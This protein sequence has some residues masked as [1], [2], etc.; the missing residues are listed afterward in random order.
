LK[1]EAKRF[2][3]EKHP[4]RLARRHAAVDNVFGDGFGFRLKAGRSFLV[5]FFKKEPLAYFCNL[6][7]VRLKS[8]RIRHG[9]DNLSTRRN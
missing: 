4:R 3:F 8:V 9:A 5:L 6:E 2:F 1:T 7:H